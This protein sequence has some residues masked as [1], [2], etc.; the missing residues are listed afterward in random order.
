MVPSAS[1]RRVALVARA[2][3][4]VL[5]LVSVLLTLHGGSA[6]VALL[7]MGYNVVTQLFP[8][9]VLS[10]GPSPRI[11][12]P[13]ALGGI[14]AGEVT[15]AAISLSGAS[16][17]TLLPGWPPVITELNVGVVALVVNVVTIL[18][19]TLA[20]RGRAPVTTV[21]RSG[22]AGSESVVASSVSP[23]A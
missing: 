16:L 4:P 21:T 2:M 9:L 14:L 5:T 15:V 19:V 10:L 3:V 1:E 7:L 17:A 8:A 6:I 22:G 11:G 13:A 12:A 18:V 23:I 20:T